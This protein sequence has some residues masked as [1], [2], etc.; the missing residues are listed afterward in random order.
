MIDPTDVVIKVTTSTICDSNLHIV[1][2]VM[3]RVE[4]S[5]ILGH[6]YV[7]KM[8]EVGSAVKDLKAGTSLL[9]WALSSLS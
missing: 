3:P 7:G 2:R 8:V 4:P 6:E 9:V 5:V 1:E